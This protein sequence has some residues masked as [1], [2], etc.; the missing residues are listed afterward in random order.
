M[1]LEL[2]SYFGKSEKT[3]STLK[4]AEVFLLQ[5]LGKE[6]FKSFDEHRLH[7]YYKSERKMTLENI[8]CFS[9]TIQLHIKTHLWINAAESQ[10]SQLDP[11]EYGYRMTDD[12]FLLPNMV[13]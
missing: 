13:A 12:G 10:F 6:E 1:D 2:E 7:Q 3:S 11:L 8:V 4:D 9:A 5:V